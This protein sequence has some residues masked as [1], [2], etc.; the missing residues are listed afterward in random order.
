MKELEF[1]I[2]EYSNQNELLRRKLIIC[3]QEIYD[4]NNASREKFDKNTDLNELI[5]NLRYEKV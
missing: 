4:I 2:S 1:K 5:S 3:E